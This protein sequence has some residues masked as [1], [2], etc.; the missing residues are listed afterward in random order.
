MMF[1]VDHAQTTLV[2]RDYQRTDVEDTYRLWESGSQGVLTRIFTGG[3]KTI[4]SSVKMERWLNQGSDYRCLVLSYEQQLVWQFAEEI[5]DVLGIT[6][7]IEMGSEEIEPGQI[8]RIVVATRQSLMCHELATGEQQEELARA[9]YTSIGLLTKRAAKSALTA[10]AKGCDP[11][12]IGDG[13]IAFN[14]RYECDHERKLFTRLTKFDWRWKW[15]VVF[16]EAHKYSVKHK[17]CGHII[18][19][20]EQNEHHRRSGITATPKRYDK[21][22]IGSKLFPDIAID[23]P[24][25]KAVQDGYAVPYLQQFVQVEGVDFRRLRE[26]SHGNQ[27]KWD[28]ELDRLLNTEGELAKLCEPVL[29]MVGCRRTLIFSPSVSMA[30]NVAAYL[31]ARAECECSCG[32]KKWFPRQLIGDGTKCDACGEWITES[33]VVSPVTVAHCVHGGINP[34]SRREVYR[35]HQS[36]EFQF[37]SV[38]ALCK[39]GYNDPDIA[40]VAVFRPVSRDAASLAEQ[41]K[42]RGSRPLKGLIEGLDS[43]ADRVAAI[44]SSSKPHCLIIDLVGVT[45]L[46]DCASTIQIYAD[47]LP[48]EIVARA[49]QYSLQGGIP[50]PELAIEQAQRD[51]VEERELARQAREEEARRRRQD[52]ERRSRLD[53]QVQYSTHES[54]SRYLS[55]SRDPHDASDSQL[56]FIHM[57]GMD[58]VGWVPSKRQ[59]SRMIELLKDKSNTPEETAYL[60]GLKS[61][62]WERARPSVKQ[63]RYMQSLGITNGQSLTPSAARRA[64]DDA[65]NPPDHAGLVHVALEAIRSCRTS[66]ELTAAARRLQADKDQFT[67]K[68]WKLVCEFGAQQRKDLSF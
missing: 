41:M 28:Q 59:A 19:W 49:E 37:L 44:A 36:G 3:G 31:N 35:A 62:W 43:V 52:A 61:E 4:C 22:S 42:G 6:P 39:E 18:E 67:E 68:D 26:V 45:G 10:I 63:I 30:E 9:G 12:D 17:T 66:T 54:G 15:L 27:E 11:Q 40:C 38:C 58:F 55:S 5:Q 23:Y 50:D 32:T 29:G 33:N 64:I 46:S 53:A 8:P 65:K 24:F 34:R 14:E 2:L 48:D 7:G 13:I 21:V 47:G 20:F 57:L 56:R 16:D 1:D 51:V 25:R 60:C